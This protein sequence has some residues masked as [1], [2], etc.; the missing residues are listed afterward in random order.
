MKRKFTESQK[1]KLLLNPNV[2]NVTGLGVIY[3]QEF[4][5]MALALYAKG[6]AANDIFVDAGFNIQELGIEN[7]VKNLSKWRRNAGLKS[8]K[9]IIPKNVKTDLG[10]RKAL[11]RIEYLEAENEFLKKLEALENQDR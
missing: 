5:Q 4:R 1:K 3:T 2:Q 7:P 10:L 9:N 11:A 6:K 8:N